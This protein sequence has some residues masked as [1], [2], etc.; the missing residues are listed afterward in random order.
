MNTSGPLE[1]THTKAKTRSVDAQNSTRIRKIKVQQYT[2]ILC[3]LRDDI[4]TTVELSDTDIQLAVESH[5]KQCANDTDL[6]GLEWEDVTVKL[7]RKMTEAS[8]DE[9]THQFACKAMERMK[10][11]TG[12]SY[13][14]IH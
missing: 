11:I 10:A 4:S 7:L 3:H 9:K 12:N 5:C 8:R 2:R 1:T 14:W 13:I 6:T